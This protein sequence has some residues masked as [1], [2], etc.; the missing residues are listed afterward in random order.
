LIINCVLQISESEKYTFLCTST[1]ISKIRHIAPKS[2]DRKDRNR[3][4]REV[5]RSKHLRN[6]AIILFIPLNRT[7]SVRT[8]CLRSRRC[9][10]REKSGSVLVRKGKGNVSRRIPL[11][12]DA[13]NTIHSYLNHREDDH[14]ALFLSTHKKRISI[15]FVQRILKKYH[16]YPHQLRH[17][18]CQELVVSGVDIATVAELG[19]SP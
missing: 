19:W 14:P 8:C 10:T 4:I 13:R 15:R 1:R 12:I 16:V 7:S 17:T 3:I 2:L 5:E 9:S 18:Y 6:I 11:P